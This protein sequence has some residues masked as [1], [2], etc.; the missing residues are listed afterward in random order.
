MSLFNHRIRYM[1]ERV[2]NTVD[3]DIRTDYN[4]GVVVDE[5]DYTSNLTGCVRKVI[6]KNLPL[7]ATLFTQK[8][9]GKFE[10]KWGVDA[11]VILIDNHFNRCKICLFEAKS[12][13]SNWDYTKPH[14]KT[15]T[16]LSH[17]STQLARQA[18][19]PKKGVLIWEQFYSSQ[20]NGLAV[21]NRSI[22]GSTC[23]LHKNAINYNGTHPNASVWGFSDI[24]HLATLQRSTKMGYLIRKVCECNYCDPIN[25]QELKE[26]IKEGIPVNNILII[27]SVKNGSNNEDIFQDIELYRESISD[28]D[29]E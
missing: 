23:I 16:P 17:F 28:V 25:K 13:T 5:N 19:L 6:N 15:K 9:P 12:D 8:V 11:C 4:L 27:E 3:T 1:L 20:P 18:L 10:R 14:R 7:R 22:Y 26:F 24:D 21:G 2:F 29:V